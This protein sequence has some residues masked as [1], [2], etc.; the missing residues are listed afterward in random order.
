[1]QHAPPKT[2]ARVARPPP[3][4]SAPLLLVVE[5]SPPQSMLV[6]WLRA[7]PSWLASMILHLVLLLVFALW[8]LPAEEPRDASLLTAAPSELAAP[9]QLPEL[10]DEVEPLEIDLAETFEPQPSVELVA[11]EP[12]LASVEG[13][14]AAATQFELSDFAEQTA[15]K[16]DLLAQA[17]GLAGGGL[18]GRGGAAR[19]ALVQRGG[20]SAGSEAAVARAL[21]WLAAHQNADGSWALDHRRGPCQ[22]RCADPGQ[23]VSDNAATALALLPF[24]GAGQTHQTGEYQQ[25]VAA[26]LMY[27]VRSMQVSN[28]KGGALN[29]GGMMYA[30]GLASIALCEAYG[31]THDPGLMAPAQA[32]LNFIVYAQDPV[33]GGWRYRPRQPGDTSVVGWQLMA[34]KSGHMAYLQV[35]RQT[36]GKA[37]QFLD[38][39]QTAGGVAYGY[40]DAGAGKATSAI[41][42]L[43]RM[44]LGWKPQHGPL[45]QGV[46]RLAQIGPSPTDLYY[47]YYATQVLFQYTGGEGPLWQRWN[48]AMRDHLIAS[49]SR[50]GH[51]EG[52]WYLGDNHSSEAGG[53]LYST[54]MAT[55]ILEVYY[56]HMPIYRTAAVEEAFPG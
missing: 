46:E 11:P 39:V 19:T 16:G 27:L 10:L 38:S 26:G 3:S 50:Q 45:E 35:P 47:N 1:M 33:G 28:T 5:E 6:L 29:D 42:L 20:G 54:S 14:S 7:T 37:S 17:G 12:E 40:T 44:Y 22:G 2:E 4:V 24:L 41:G 43:S 18:S 49:Q 21:A 48:R 9:E 15:P 53:R 25:P 51:A 23:K 56:R 30:H 36:V 13:P 52:S 32:S 31:M 34:L 55:M 8:M